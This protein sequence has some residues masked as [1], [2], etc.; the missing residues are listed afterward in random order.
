MADA[1][2]INEER[3]EV[4]EQYRKKIV[5]HRNMESK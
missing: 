2:G 4:L 1:G 5:E 3:K